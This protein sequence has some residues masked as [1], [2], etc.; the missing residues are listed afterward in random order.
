MIILHN[1]PS[2]LLSQQR[3][4]KVVTQVEFWVFIKGQQPVS[5]LNLG[6]WPHAPALRLKGVN[7]LRFLS[8]PSVPGK[9]WACQCHL[10]HNMF[11]RV[12]YSHF[13]FLTSSLILCSVC[14]FI[15]MPQGDPELVPMVSFQDLK[16][17]MQVP[18]RWPGQ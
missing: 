4:L 1:F 7:S 18:G 5:P 17:S 15:Q 2:K 6:N 12:P 9:V 13:A 3:C 8:P 10:L 16:V 11:G 14:G